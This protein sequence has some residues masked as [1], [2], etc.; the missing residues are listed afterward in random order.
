[1]NSSTSV[2]V[3]DQFRDKAISGGE[4]VLCSGLS[5][6]GL[7][8]AEVPGDQPAAT[9]TLIERSVTGLLLLRATDSATAL[10]EALHARCGLALS[11][12]LHS[13]SHAQYCVRWMSPDSWLLSC[14]LDEAFAIEND[15]RNSVNG[16]IAIVNVSG[17]Y[18]IL[19]LAG[20]HAREVLMK[21]TGYDIHPDHLP[22]DKVVNTTFAK[23]QVTLR[24]IELSKGQGRY[25]LLV[26]RSFCDYVWLWLQRASVE[27]GLNAITEQHGGKI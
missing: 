13:K 11:T 25:E 2:S 22:Q 8:I 15:L 10:S 21:S 18:S 23:T 24:C 14:P 5:H 1:M 7:P 16:H 20:I 19:E 4:S 27:Y 3:L 26:R 17:G 12:R 6:V 9:V